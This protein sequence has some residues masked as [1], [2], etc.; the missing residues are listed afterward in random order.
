MLHSS[1]GNVSVRSNIVGPLPKRKVSKS[2]RNRRR[3]HD[4]ISLPHLVL[5][6]DTGEYRR[7]HHVCKKTGM[8][9]GEQVIEV[10]ND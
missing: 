2:R 10:D 8:Y 7:A 9:K 1:S 3:A 4:R 6:P 5:D